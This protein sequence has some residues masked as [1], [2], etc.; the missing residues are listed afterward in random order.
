MASIIPAIIPSSFQHLQS[1]VEKVKDLVSLVQVDIADGL[2]VKNKTWPYVGDTGEFEKLTREELGLPFWEDVDYEFHL[3]IENPQACIE[4]WIHAGASSIIVQIEARTDMESVIAMCKAA[5][6]SFGLSLKPSTD[7]SKISPFVDKIDFLQCM[8][9]ND[10]GH[11]GATL[12][13]SVYDKIKQLH[14]LYPNVPIAVDIG[15]SEETAPKFV[16]AGATKLV[17]GGAIF[18]T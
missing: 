14:T 4:D 8:G 6:V 1:E 15:V 2:F 5:E 7:I 17:S 13:V 10:L 16:A 9:S 18:E 11:H 12:D 3:M